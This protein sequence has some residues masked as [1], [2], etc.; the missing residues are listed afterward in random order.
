[1]N[2]FFDIGLVIILA[3]I[4]GFV[5]KA[6]KQPM[7]SFY[8][9]AGVIIGPVLNLIK[10]IAVMDVLS[11]IGIAFLL[12]IVGIELDVKRLKEVGS[13][14]SIGAIIQMALV[15]GLAALAFFLIGFSTIEGIYAGIIV[16]FSSTMVII[17]LLADKSQLDTLH[18]RIIVGTLLVQDVVAVIILS[19]ISNS[20]NFSAL[21]LIWSIFQALLLFVSALFFSKVLFPKL[22]KFAAKSQELF[23]LLSI[24]VCFSFAI[25]FASIGFS[26]AIGAFI[27]GLMLGNLPYNV[28]IISKVRNLRDFFATL[29]FVSMGVKLSF[30]ALGTYSI[31][32]IILVIITALIAPLITYLST[33]SF[34]YNKKTSFLTAIALTQVSEFALIAVDQGVKAGHV[35]RD[36]LSLTILVMLVTIMITSYLLK[37][38]H[39]LYRFLLPFLKIFDRFFKYKKQI[40]HGHGKGHY[41][42]VLIGYDR[43][44]F[45]IYKSLKTLKMKTI[46]VDFNPDIISRLMNQNKACLYGDISDFEVMEELHLDKVET[47]ISTIPDH[48]DTLLLIKQVRK[49]NKEARII[50]TAYIVEEALNFYNQGADYVILPHLLGGAHAGVFLEEVSNDFDKLISTK[51]AHIDELKKHSVRKKH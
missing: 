7:I 27:A 22:F 20:G 28:E 13:V 25:L 33:R 38:E 26:I 24:S 23:F 3:T 2:I 4:G 5:A 48:Q 12:F 47:I 35:G 11:E 15:F 8:I 46:I 21:T 51:I 31:G 39:K 30:S 9:L 29:F 45:N 44:G 42:V 37:Y 34:G 16:L 43:I 41:K 17:K 50:V 19:L 18:G 36:F 49:I 10:D 32:F 40:K 1:M 6:L 14:A